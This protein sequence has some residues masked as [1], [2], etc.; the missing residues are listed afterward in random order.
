MDHSVAQGVEWVNRILLGDV[1][2]RAHLA[3][4]ARLL[5]ATGDWGRDPDRSPSQD[6]VKAD[7][8]L[9]FRLVSRLTKQR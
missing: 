2:R 7:L 3:G 6:R 8:H 9:P 4:E 1:N 5:S